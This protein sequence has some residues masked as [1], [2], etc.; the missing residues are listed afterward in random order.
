M[1]TTVQKL[2]KILF[3]CK[4]H[5]SHDP[6]TASIKRWEDICYQV[7]ENNRNTKCPIFQMYLKLLREEGYI[8]EDEIPRA[9]V[10]GLLFKGYV[11]KHYSNKIFGRY[12]TVINWSIIAAGLGG[13]ISVFY[14][15]LE[16]YVKLKEFQ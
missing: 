15:I 7:A 9:T 3:A 12:Q 13:L 5:V 10:K 1:Q 6:D 16:I 11:E 4:N 14:Y 8:N 2:D